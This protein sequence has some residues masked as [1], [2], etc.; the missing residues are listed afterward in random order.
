LGLQSELLVD[1]LLKKGRYYYRWTIKDLSHSLRNLSDCAE[2]SRLIFDT[3]VNILKLTGGCLLA[4]QRSN[5][6]DVIASQGGYAEK[7]KLINL[8]SLVSKRTQKQE[9]PNPASGLNPELAYI[10]PLIAD[11]KEVGVLCV[12]PKTNRHV[13]SLNKIYFNWDLLLLLQ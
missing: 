8:T 9:F 12:S 4:K 3:A 7:D 11:G 6:Y 10:I 2:T 1:Q 13:F 5:S